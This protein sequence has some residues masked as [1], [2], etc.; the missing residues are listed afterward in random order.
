MKIA[1]LS[2]IH[3][4]IAALDAVLSHVTS[5]AVDQIVNL[6]DICSGALWPHE[7]ATRLMALN[8]PTIRGNH[9]RQVLA[10]ERAA[11]GPSDRL[12]LDTLTE[13]QLSWLAALP[14]T[15]RLND[16]VILVHG[17][18]TS[19]LVYF[20]ESVDANGIRPA[21]MTEIEDRAGNCQI[22][23]ILCGHTHIP[24]AVRLPDGRLIVNPGSV[25]LPAYDDDRPFPHAVE[26]LSPHAR[27]AT[28]TNERGAWEVSFHLVSYDWEKAALDAQAHDRPDWAK[29]LR[30]G[31]V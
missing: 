8:L 6:G 26:N 10:G 14:E 27:Y 28:V 1:V 9:E 20:L 12:A 21:N 17:T 3:G 2:D 7:T 22:P 13:D 5:Q 16:D 18:P 25:G 11:M 23:L 24:R 30:T 15:L 29:A 31:M 4:N 19:D